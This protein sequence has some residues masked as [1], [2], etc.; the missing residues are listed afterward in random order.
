MSEERVNF[1]LNPEN[2]ED[3]AI[4]EW[5]NTQKR[6]KKS[7]A[8]K[9]ALISYLSGLIV[10]FDPQNPVDARIIESIKHLEQEPRRAAQSLKNMAYER[11]TGKDTI[12]GEPLQ[13]FV[14]IVEKP[15]ITEKVKIV[16]ELVPYQ[17]QGHIAEPETITSDQGITDESHNQ[18]VDVDW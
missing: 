12:T 7:D 11:L 17:A 6:G 10:N 18:I 9:M 8:I 3:Q 15:V 4:I 16:R 1:R 5:L 2:E 14:K 13:A